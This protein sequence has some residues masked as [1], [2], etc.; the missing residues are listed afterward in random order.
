[1]VA[2]LFLILS[3]QGELNT[4]AGQQE[5]RLFDWQQFVLDRIGLDASEDESE[6]LLDYLLFRSQNPYCLSLLGET[7]LVQLG[8]LDA[9]ETDAIMLAKPILTELVSRLNERVSLV[10]DFATL[11]ISMMTEMVS[12]QLNIEVQVIRVLGN[13]INTYPSC[14]VATEATPGIRRFLYDK[15]RPAIT[16]ENRVQF[17]GPRGQGYQNGNYSGSPLR[18]HDRYTA[19]G[20]T[21]S[22]HL[23]RSKAA[24]EDF[25]APMRTGFQS[26]HLAASPAANWYVI[27]GDYTIQ[28]GAGLGS[29]RSA[30]RTGTRVL[31]RFSGIA[32]VARPYRSGN[33]GRFYRGVTATWSGGGSRVLVYGSTRKLSAT[34]V[35]HEDQRIG[36]RFPGWTSFR[37]TSGERDRHHNLN[38]N[39]MGVDVYRSHSWLNLH[40]EHR[41]GLSR[42]GFSGEIIPRD[43]LAYREHF[44][45]SNLTAWSAASQLRYGTLEAMTEWSGSV[46][47]GIARVHGLRIRQG[48]MDGGVWSRRYDRNHYTVF[49]SGIGAFSGAAN[50]RGIGAWVVVRPVRGVRVR[51]YA[52]RYESVGVRPDAD[53]GVWGWERGTAA[54]VRVSRGVLVRGEAIIRGVLR[55]VDME[56]EFG[57][58]SR[59]RVERERVT[60][61]GSVRVEPG[62]GWLW[63]GRADV[64]GLMGV[65]P[66]IGVGR[67]GGAGVAQVMRYR[68]DQWEFIVQHHIFHADT[69]DTRVYAYE[70]DLLNVIRIPSFSGAGQRYSTVI[71]YQPRSWLLIRTKLGRTKYSDRFAVGSGND[72]TDGPSRTD[73]GIQIITRF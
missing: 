46:Q 66:D 57:R 25:Q 4:D 20:S 71:Q 42:H 54:D 35:L 38:L 16:T 14:G 18:Y 73:G 56:D 7:E 47:G 26:F 72:L 8:F 22:A 30:M 12:S 9:F 51:M 36:F 68:N 50:E 24:G 45:G 69:H 59:V 10:P 17:A 15:Q 29:S 64:Q 65:V 11:Y 23:A 21:Y 44:A 70:Y 31:Q 34:E 41:V 28:S 33:H 32:P 2:V 53:A 62:A 13:F 37:R 60:V 19:E 63:Q 61:R 6:E 48:N 5:G 40:L 1:M 49:G 67:L 27:L 43:G 58:V 39:S 3:S 52:D 55:G